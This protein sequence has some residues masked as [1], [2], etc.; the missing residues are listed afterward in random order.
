LQNIYKKINEIV[1][2]NIPAAL[3]TVTR[4]EG[5]TPRNAGSKMI[6][7]E[8]GS[9]FGTIGGSMVEVKVI[10]EAKLCLQEGK[11]NRVEHNLNDLEKDD[12]GMVCGG[13][14]EFFIEPLALSSHIYI[15]GAGHVGLPLAKFAREVGF[16]YSL[17]EDREQFAT[18][19]RFPEAK[20]IIVEEPGEAAGK[21][22]FKPSDFLAIVTRSHDQDYSVLKAV[23][24]KSVKYIGLIGSK[25]K[26]KQIFSKLREDGFNEKQLKQIHTPIGLDI[27]AQSPE[28]IAISIVAELIKIKNKN[29]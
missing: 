27:N 29:V 25:V 26:S 11:S 24:N 2:Q 9:I 3:V 4:T 8:D 17:I 20:N 7:Y 19:E 22:N 13:N 10:E 5:S 21:I 18:S 6:V 12:T 1:D 23:L 14:M 16:S 28:E 15:F